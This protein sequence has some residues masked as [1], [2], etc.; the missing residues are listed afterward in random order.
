MA[1]TVHTRNNDILG[2]VL[3]LDAPIRVPH[4][5]I[6]RVQ[7]PAGEELA[8]G[9]GVFVVALAADV[10]REDN[11]AHLLAVLGHVDQHALGLVGF[12][13]A[14]GERRQE[15]MS[16]PCHVGELLVLGQA[17]PLR[18]HIAPRDGTVSLGQPVDV[19]R[20]QVEIGHLLEKVGCR[21]AGGHRHPDRVG[22][23]LGVLV[24]AEER[25]DGRGGVEVRDPFFLQQ[26]PDQGVVDFAQADVRPA[27]GAHRPGKCPSH[28][29]EPV[30]EV[31]TKQA[32]LE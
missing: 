23:D 3:D 12:D 13:D 25:V 14:H 27:D 2:P 22:E 20:D 16:L 26:P 6:T 5:E 28:S 18:K 30:R 1:C 19:H 21:R 7:H 24:G 17:V 15:T 11:L 10:A 29:V 31:S 4:G 9:L 8:G 32:L